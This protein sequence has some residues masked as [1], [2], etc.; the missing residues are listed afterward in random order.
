MAWPDAGVKVESIPA[1]I[2]AIT[3]DAIINGASMKY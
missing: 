2:A 1:P 3:D